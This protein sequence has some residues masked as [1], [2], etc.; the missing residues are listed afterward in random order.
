MVVLG[1]RR[2]TWLK[3]LNASQRNCTYL[4]S[5]NANFFISPR[6]TTCELGPSRI[7]IPELPKRYGPG[8]SKAPGLNHKLALGFE[9]SGFP[10]KLGRVPQPLPRVAPGTLNVSGSPEEKR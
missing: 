10:I 3:A 6:L 2:F 4:F 5:P 8:L 9:S 7:P 1:S